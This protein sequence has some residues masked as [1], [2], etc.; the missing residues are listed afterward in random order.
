[1]KVQIVIKQG[2]ETET[3]IT[4]IEESF[5]SYLTKVEYNFNNKE[6]LPIKVN[7]NIVFI[8]ID[9]IKNSIIEFKEID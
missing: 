8:G 6:P 5:K 3:Y 9:V 4:E 2:K 1:M 7:N